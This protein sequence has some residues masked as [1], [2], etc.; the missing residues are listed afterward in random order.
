MTRASLPA[1]VAVRGPL[2]Y[3][4]NFWTNDTFRTLFFTLSLAAVAW[5][6]F[7]AYAALRAVYGRS[8]LAAV[9]QLLLALAGPLI[10]LGGLVGLVGLEHAL[11]AFNDQMAILPLGLSRILGITVH[12]D[13]PLDLPLYILGLG[14]GLLA[15][16]GLLALLARAT[17]RRARSGDSALT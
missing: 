16:G 15:A 4:A 8:A 17:G 5:S 7:A 11:T 3:W 12:L 10:V 13:I 14:L 2:F 1:V 9:G 6:F